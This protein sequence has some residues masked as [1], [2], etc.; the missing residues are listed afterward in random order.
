MYEKQEGQNEAT[1]DATVANKRD[2]DQPDLDN[3]NS[4]GDKLK[5]NVS[6]EG[7]IKTGNFNSHPEKPVGI[8]FF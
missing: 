3:D 7:I 6:M 1:V 8:N 2:Q 4:P 5:D